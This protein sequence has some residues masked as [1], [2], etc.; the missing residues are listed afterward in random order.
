M[1]VPLPLARQH[2]AIA[3]ALVSGVLVI[4]GCGSSSPTNGTKQTTAKLAA[5]AIR[6][7]SCMRSHGVT[8]FPDPTVSARGV[9]FSVKSSSGINPSG[10]SFLAAQTA[11]GKLLPRGG[12]GAGTPSAA[13]KA[14]MLAIAQCMRAHG[15]NGFPDPTTTPPSSPAGY[16]GVLGRN[17]VYFAIPSTIDIQSPAVQHAATACRLSGLGAGG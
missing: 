2:G 17:G 15:V 4:G 9:G 14:Q 13:S 8:N 11:C 16:S 7:A 10:P 6:F 3:V 1:S 5:S 12:P